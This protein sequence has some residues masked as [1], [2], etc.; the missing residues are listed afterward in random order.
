MSENPGDLTTRETEEL[1]R[2]KR[3]L[4]EAR[5]NSIKRHVWEQ[6]M[7]ETVPSPTLPLYPGL[8]RAVLEALR[9]TVQ[10]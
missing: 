9:A 5:F 7:R 6:H 8:W 1:L 4:G 2:L 10:H 3:T